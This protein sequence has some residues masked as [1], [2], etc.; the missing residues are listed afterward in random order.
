MGQRGS[1][2]CRR[3][4]H[5]LSLIGIKLETIRAH[6]A[7]YNIIVDGDR[8]VSQ[9]SRGGGRRTGTVNLAVVGIL[10][11][12]QTVLGDDRRARLDVGPRTDPS[13]S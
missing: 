6:P 11:Q 7:R 13:G 10:M 4:P 12:R 5:H 8:N 2:D 9:Q 1:C 3:T